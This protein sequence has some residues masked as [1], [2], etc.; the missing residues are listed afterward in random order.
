MVIFHY[1][2]VGALG[3]SIELTISHKQLV[4]TALKQT[5]Q[6]KKQRQ[7]CGKFDSFIV[8]VFFRVEMHST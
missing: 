5:D 3:G 2:P 4:A 8:F 6:Q 1:N 7:F